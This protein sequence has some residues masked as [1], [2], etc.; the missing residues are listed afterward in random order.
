MTAHERMQVHVPWMPDDAVDSS[1]FVLVIGL[2][3]IAI[4]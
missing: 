3:L 4:E 1:A 2:S